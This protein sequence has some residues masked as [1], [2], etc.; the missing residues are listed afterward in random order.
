MTVELES[1]G[2]QA[3]VTDLGRDA[4]GAAAKLAVED[5]SAA[6]A[7]S[8]SD[9]EQVVDAVAGAE[10]ELAPSRCVCIVLQNDG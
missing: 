1:V 4:K 10:D 7:G 6:D 2:D 9:E 8:D 3:K 5:E